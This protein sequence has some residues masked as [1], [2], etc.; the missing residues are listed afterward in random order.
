MLGPGRKTAQRSKITQN[1]FRVPV[2][3]TAG[4]TVVA[5]FKEVVSVVVIVLLSRFDLFAGD[6]LL[7]VANQNHT[8]Y[9]ASWRRSCAVFLALF[10]EAH[11]Q[12]FG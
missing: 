11:R 9:L 8:H 6:V 10:I 7:Q 12:L 5:V 3:Q 4:H 2:Q 1:N